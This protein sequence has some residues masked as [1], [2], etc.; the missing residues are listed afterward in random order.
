[1]SELEQHKQRQ[2]DKHKKQLDKREKKIKEKEDK[3][4]QQQKEHTETQR[5]LERER[6]EL[7]KIKRNLSTKQA[8]TVHTL[9]E[10]KAKEIKHHFNKAASDLQT[11]KQLLDNTKKKLHQQTES[12][13]KLK[14]ANDDKDVRIKSL[15]RKTKHLTKGKQN[16][17]TDQKPKIKYL[18]AQ[19]ANLKRRLKISEQIKYSWI[20]KENIDTSSTQ[21]IE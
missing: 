21:N 14:E 9:A 3:L 10:S 1:M 6:K 2:L 20:K 16:I 17:Y 19:V 5:K 7:N 4:R 11:T 15:I 12:V 8:S 13:R 18:N